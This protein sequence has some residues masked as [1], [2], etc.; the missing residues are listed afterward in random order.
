MTEAAWL[1]S[2]DPLEMF[3]RVV[4]PLKLS[5]TRKDHFCVACAQLVLHL[6]QDEGA[7]RAF[8]WLAE[9]PGERTRAANRCHEFNNRVQGSLGS[10]ATRVEQRRRPKAARG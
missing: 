6:I 2:E 5:Q 1:T 10:F 4:R 9:H 3:E 7:K 8:E